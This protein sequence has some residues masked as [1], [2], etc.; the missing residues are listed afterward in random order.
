MPPITSPADVRRGSSLPIPAFP[1]ACLASRHGNGRNASWSLF[2]LV[3]LLPCH[4]ETSNRPC[5]LHANNGHMHASGLVRSLSMTQE[6]LEVLGLWLK[7]GK[8]GSP[9][10]PVF[11]VRS[12]NQFHISDDTRCEHVT[13][14]CVLLSCVPHP[15]TNLSF[16]KRSTMGRPR[17]RD[18]RHSGL[19]GTAYVRYYD[20]LRC[21]MPG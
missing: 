11:D 17:S 3:D 9:V 15:L 5:S 20:L 13:I 4:A 18:H 8:T 7:R 14:R 19:E 2:W 21:I 10:I 1:S 16:P 6:G 12:L